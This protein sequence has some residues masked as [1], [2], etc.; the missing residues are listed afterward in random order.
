MTVITMPDHVGSR[1]ATDGA[2]SRATVPTRRNAPKAAGLEVSHLRKSYGSTVAVDDLSFGVEAGEI[3]GLVGPN[4]A[5]KSTA[6]MIVAGVR[7]ADSGVVTIAGQ[8]GGQGNAVV[9]TML[10]LVPQ[11]LAIYPD[12]TARENLDF[13][14]QIYRVG[15]A[16]L[17]RRTERVLAQ[18]GL[19]HHANQ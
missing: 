17:K 11:D 13:F 19:E 18:V 1:R 3:L 10:G 2:S 12:L 15:R 9:Q 8:V 5:G 14:G 4:G 16:E 7:S 6:M